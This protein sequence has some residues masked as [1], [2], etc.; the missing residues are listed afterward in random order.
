MSGWNNFL[1]TMGLAPSQAE[2]TE[3]VEFWH[4]AERRAGS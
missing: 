3:G 2:L 4:G 1:A